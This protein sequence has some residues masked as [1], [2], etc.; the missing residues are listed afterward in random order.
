MVIKND[1]YQI[2]LDHYSN[3]LGK[4]ITQTRSRKSVYSYQ[5]DSKA[6]LSWEIIE[7]R[8]LSNTY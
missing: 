5:W 2:F 1:K 4:L 6:I 7:I 8:E 3:E